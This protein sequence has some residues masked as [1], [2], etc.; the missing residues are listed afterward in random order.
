MNLNNIIKILKSKG[1]LCLVL[2]GI[3]IY[4]ALHVTALAQYVESKLLPP[5]S[6]PDKRVT[7][8]TGEAQSD[9]VQMRFRVKETI[10][11]DYENL[12]EDGSAIDLKTP[13]N[14]T[15]EAEYDAVTGMYVV[16]TKLGDKEITTPFMLSADEYNNIELRKSMQ[17]YYRA[18]NSLTAEENKKDTFSFL[19]MQFGLGPLDKVFGPGGVQLKTQGSVKINMGIKSNKTDNPALS[20]DARRKTYFDFDQQIQANINASVGD[21][22]KFD[23]SYNTGATFDFD[24]KNLKLAYEGKEDEIIKNIEAG[25]VSMTTGSSLIRG[26]TSLFG[27]KTKL[28]FG[29]LTAT[30]L[31]SQ[32]N[33]QTQTVNSRGGAQT[34]QFTV[35]AD[36]YDQNR[37]Y[38]LSH[39]FRDNYD[40]F[41]STLPLVSSGI[42][43]TRIEVWV[44]NK[45]NDYSQ[46]RNVVAFMDLGE[47]RRLANSHWVGNAAVDVPCNAS[48]NLITEISTDYPDAR[49]IEQ[50]ATALDPLMAYGFEG[51][52]DYEKVESARLLSS[53]EYTLNTSLGY[54]S[55]KS[56]LNADEVLAVAYQYT[57]RGQTYQVGEFAGDVASTKESLYVKL[58][59][60]TTIST[61]MPMWDLAMKNVYSLGAYQI[62][63]SNFKLNIKY[64]SDTTG[65][66]INYLPA[67][68]IS[69]TPLIRVMNL[70]RLDSNNQSNPDG[71]FDY[72]EGY[73][74]NSS[75]GKIYFP[76]V[77]PFGTH[78]ASKIGNPVLAEKYV[79]QELYD[80]TLT[81]AR[82]FQDKNKFVLEGE[83]QAS[84]G[85]QI[86]LN[87]MNVARGSVVVT[88]GGVTLT[89]N[90][91]YTVDYNMGI[92]T[93]IN[94]S[95]IDAGTNISVTLENQSTYSTQRKTLLGLDLNYK[96]NK[97]FNI[98][99]T[100]MHYGEKSLTEKVSIGDEMV[101][102]T[103]WG[104]NLSYNTSFMWLTNLVNKIPT[105]N[106]TAPS[107]FSFKGEFAQL[108]PHQQK[109]GSNKGSSYI[110]DFEST[111]SGLDLRSPYSWFLCAT[112]YDNSANALFPEASLSNNIDYGKNRALLSW[113]YIDRM[114]TQRNSSLAPGYIKNDLTQL[115]N[116]YVREVTYA[117]VYPG[118]ELSYGESSTLQTLNLS[119]YPN[120][121]GPYNL[122]VAGMNPDGTLMNPE[123]RWGGI[124]R[125]LDATNF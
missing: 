102:N 100:L 4:S 70:D 112:P 65:T 14:I 56:A 105:V 54:I 87:A 81:V 64:M 51:G 18:R 29:K 98:G 39:W 38:F 91:D 5:P 113:Y 55:L 61:K 107:T 79:Y 10:P 84:S 119:Y 82:Q 99:A 60:G 69:G 24:N 8:A 110:D 115:S 76:V 19:D 21:K 45:R 122:D 44:T 1:L 33:S 63:S 32:Q 3:V 93:I 85:S 77:E 36:S 42:N 17:E 75:N 16:R 71:R 66:Y 124:M 116:P 43:I 37:H 40:K 117:E 80:S 108:I 114:F 26:S 20:V 27:V 47:N 34:Q 72:I 41:A 53:S 74:V 13:K 46:S 50:V 49:Y 67:G 2:C 9:S 7:A 103:I 30:A 23:M 95:I 125:K 89:E 106:A 94:Q 120:E 83:Y 25:N 88:A 96:F 15:T 123:K 101:N 22:M 118:R 57:Y 31:V 35:T 121:R 109:T 104:L 48:N 68:A 12:A 97:D 58:L 6:V 78:L 11:A 52:R 92:V 62:Q 90:S 28:Q 59:K 73:T 111:Q 86:R